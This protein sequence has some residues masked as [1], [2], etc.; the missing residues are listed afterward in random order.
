MTYLELLLKAVIRVRVMLYT[1]VFE[2]RGGDQ[3]TLVN[4]CQ[5]N[6]I[7]LSNFLVLFSPP[8]LINIMKYE[9]AIY[10]THTSKRNDCFF[11]HIA[12]WEMNSF[13]SSPRQTYVYIEI[14]L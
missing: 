6:L 14:S 4:G 13:I 8:V 7:R 2:L 1:I 9:R 12:H 11:G 3:F 5:I 10:E